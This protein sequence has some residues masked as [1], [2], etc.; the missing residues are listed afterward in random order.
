VA[1]NTNEVGI[2]LRNVLCTAAT[3]PAPAGTP[4]LEHLEPELSTIASALNLRETIAKI[5]VA[6]LGV[7]EL[8][9]D[10]KELGGLK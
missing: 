1:V 5:F 7:T 10:G 8:L 9:V 4:A 3:F 2:F 6:G